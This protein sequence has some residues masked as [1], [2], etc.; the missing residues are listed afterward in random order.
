MRSFLFLTSATIC[1][2]VCE[3]AVGAVSTSECSGDIPAQTA[4]YIDS[5]LRAL[6][7]E[8][9]TDEQEECVLGAHGEM[10]RTVSLC[11]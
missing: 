5:S 2:T 10:I 3:A 1:L 4:S 9:P 7:L 11:R 8:L 6:V